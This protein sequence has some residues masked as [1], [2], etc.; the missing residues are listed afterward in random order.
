MR[1]K[2]SIYLLI[3]LLT[4]VVFAGCTPGKQPPVLELNFDQ[5]EAYFT[6]TKALSPI[7]G[8]TLDTDIDVYDEA[9]VKLTASHAR[10]LRVTV[11]SESPEITGLRAAVTHG[12][13]TATVTLANHAVLFESA[14][15]ITAA[16]LTVRV[17]L[18]SDTPRESAGLTYTFALVL[19]AWEA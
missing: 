14:D 12:G 10:R 6:S 17:Y 5:T 19:G 1:K 16:D 2:T 8:D 9:T 7:V 13:N 11:E 18:A 4:V 3:A 15:E